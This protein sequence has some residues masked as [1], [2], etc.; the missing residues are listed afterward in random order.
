[1]M[2]NNYKAKYGEITNDGK[3]Y[4]LTQDA[5]PTGGSFG[6]DDGARYDGNWYEAHAVDED[7]NE[8]TIYWTRV[9]WDADSGDACD[10]DNPDY[11]IAT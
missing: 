1:M 11:I 8:Y 6:T 2:Y 9:N 3:A 7:G 5:Y 4:A 10:W